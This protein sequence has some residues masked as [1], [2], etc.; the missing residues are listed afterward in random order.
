MHRSTYITPVTVSQGPLAAHRRDNRA[1][2]FK[3]ASS[4]AIHPHK[5]L[6]RHPLTP[7][8][9]DA[10][11]RV[12]TM[13]AIFQSGTPAMQ[14]LLQH[15]V[16]VASSCLLAANIFCLAPKHSA[17]QQR[18]DAYKN[19][20]K[21][22]AKCPQRRLMRRYGVSSRDEA[23]ELLASSLAVSF[24]D[25]E[26]V[27]VVILSFSRMFESMWFLSHFGVACL[28]RRRRERGCAERRRGKG[29]GWGSEAV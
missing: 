28:C 4:L 14:Q 17:L 7:L 10:M 11:K 1:R 21:T 27:F 19:G 26:F 8:P 3:Q 2:S 6:P 12:T 20:A 29:G 9:S 23:L 18:I 16:A 15:D 22:I 24:A 25:H 5:Q 13:S